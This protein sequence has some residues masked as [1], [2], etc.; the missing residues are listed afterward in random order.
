MEETTE[1]NSIC[2]YMKTLISLIMVNLGGRT[3][4]DYFFF[5]ISL[6]FPHE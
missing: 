3:I 5:Y 2:D 6:N 1:E 4:L